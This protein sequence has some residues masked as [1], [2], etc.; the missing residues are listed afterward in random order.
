MANTNLTSD[1][2][3]SEA[4]MVLT[5]KQNFIGSINRG[6]DP[7]FAKK[8]GKV[9][10][11]FDIR[12]PVKYEVSDGATLVKQ[13]STQS[14]VRLQITK[15]KH[16]GVSFTSRELALDINDFRELFLM[17]AM[18]ELAAQMEADAMSMYQ[19][20]HQQV[21]NFGGDPSFVDLLRAERAITDALAPDDMRCLNLGT[22]HNL[23]LVNDLKGYYHAD[24]NISKQYHSG[25]VAGNV[26]GF[27]KVYRNTLWPRHESGKA[28]AA[29]VQGGNQSGDSINIDN[30]NGSGND[31][32]RKGDVVHF[33]GVYSVHPQTKSRRSWL[34]PFV[35]RED[36]NS[37]SGSLKIY[38]DLVHD[39]P[40]RNVSGRPGDNKAVTIIQDQYNGGASEDSEEYDVSMAY[41]KNAFAFG[42]VDLPLPEGDAVWSSRKNH[43]GISMRIVRQYDINDD[44]FPCRIDVLYGYKAVRPQLACRL[45]F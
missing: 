2:I 12:L 44:T 15:R 40:F 24:P 3:L 5:Q 27:Q 21:G 1:I 45:A 28:T 38:P 13:D 10:D 31:R 39:G 19:D 23:A 25:M 30:V 35:V 41:Q 6:Y 16:V 18:S 29:Q 34:A 37:S 11:F 17:E 4:L 9:G 32:F 36:M 33:E 43:D 42:T 20:V 14:S 8:G 7:Q 22:G 26:S